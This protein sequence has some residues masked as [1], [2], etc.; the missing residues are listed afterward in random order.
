VAAIATLEPA[1]LTVDP[2]GSGSVVV[3]IRNSGSIVDRFEVSVVGPLAAWARP[4]PASLSLF[5][6][7][8]GEAQIVFALPREPFPRA[9]T[10]PF[11]V[12]VAPEADPGG[13]TV[14]EGR[15]VVGAF[16]ELAA[17]IVPQTSRASRVGRHEIVIENRGNAPVE[18][19]VE[20]ADPDRLVAFTVTPDRLIAGPGERT[21]TS[22][23]AAARD[24]FMLGAKRSHPFNVE[25]RA[26]K[27]TPIALRGTLLQGP[28]L[29][30][31][32]LPL[33]AIAVLAIVAILVLPGLTGS[34]DPRTGVGGTPTPTP[35][36]TPTATPTATPVSLPPSEP[37]SPTP[38][39]APGEFVV[40]L[41]NE[42]E[43]PMSGALQLLC[44]ETD[45]AC[46]QRV[47][48][49]LQLFINALG[50]RYDGYGVANP[51][52][53]DVPN[54]LPVVL[55]RDVAFNW[56]SDTGATGTT[57]VLLV[58]LAPLI[59]DTPSYAYAV[60]E[61]GDGTTQRFVVPHGTADQ[62]FKKLYAPVP[63]VDLPDWTLP[64]KADIA[65]TYF[66]NNAFYDN[67]FLFITPTP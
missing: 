28:I 52:Q 41:P 35:T 37:P 47:R 55:S 62:L 9:G 23:R 54:T 65:Q 40:S 15:V 12:R 21:G 6:G 46:R 25:I 60:V 11:G 1:N 51:A 24:T 22:L 10:L 32:L 53:P 39:P 3:R 18:V 50:A 30:A 8:E 16:T 48:D 13:T 26:A 45:D 64:D 43:P 7:Q 33:G 61:T 17:E 4:Q 59:A 20:A 42:D 19:S 31:W 38:T 29:P 66:W 58:D 14:E 63:Q 5:P 44:P 36:P 34:R 67:L 2:G 56:R 27:S 49:D 57:D